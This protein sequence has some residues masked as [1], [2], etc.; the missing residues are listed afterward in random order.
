MTFLG[1]KKK[2]PHQRLGRLERASG[3]GTLII[4][5]GIA[6]EIG[7]F[8]GLD[9]HDPL[10]RIFTLV[11]NCLIALGLIIEYF[12]IQF[13]ISASEE[14]KIESDTKIAEAN[15]RAAEANERAL[16][17]QLE[18]ARFRTARVA[19]LKE[20]KGAATLTAALLPFAGTKFDVGHEDVGRE[21]W[22]FL[23]LLEPIFTKA[24]WVHVDWEGGQYFKKSNWPGDHTYGV[25]NVSNVSIEVHPGSP[26]ALVTAALALAEALN[27]IGVQA[28]TGQFNNVSANADAIHVLVGTKG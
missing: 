4:L 24:G 7:I 5:V 3:W 11:A 27:S 12:A 10:E 14:A 15:A 8:I 23:W 18:L 28:D 2:D 19:L 6:V 9:P 13:T 16:A 20:G 1:H 26:E 17:M 22:D 21:Q 25:A